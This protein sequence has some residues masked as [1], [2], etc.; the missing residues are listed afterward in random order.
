MEL[1][2]RILFLTWFFYLFTYFYFMSCSYYL[3]VVTRILSR[4][5][6]FSKLHFCTLISLLLYSGCSFHLLFFFFFLPNNHIILL[7]LVFICCPHSSCSM[8]LC[9]LR[10]VLACKLTNPSWK[11][12]FTNGLQ[13]YLLFK[14]RACK[15]IFC[16]LTERL[17]TNLALLLLSLP[18]MA[19]MVCWRKFWFSPVSCVVRVSEL[20]IWISALFT[21]TKSAKRHNPLQ[22]FK[23]QKYACYILWESKLPPHFHPFCSYPCFHL[24]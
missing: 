2:K 22:W 3:P 23:H 18:A 5:P 19:M 9:T 11:Y 21:T 12:L 13:L 7:G 15:P 17:R 8:C 6:T 10:T 16:S 20:T 1:Y 24:S 14:P 4:N